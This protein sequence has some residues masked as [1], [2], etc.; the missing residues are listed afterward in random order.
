MNVDLEYD[1]AE[2]LKRQQ[3]K[4]SDVDSLRALVEKHQI[5]PKSITNKQVRGSIKVLSS[6]CDWNF[7]S[8]QLLLFLDACGGPEEGAR[9]A[10]IYYEIKKNSPEHF[11]NRDP[12]SPQIQQCLS[13]Q[14]YFYLPNKPNGDLIVFHRLSSSRASDYRFDEAIKTFFM[15]IDSCLQK[16]G[17]RDGAI[18]LFDMKNVGLM[19]LTRVNL[20]S[21]KKF[22]SYLQEGVPG[23][24]RAIHVLNTVYFMEKILAMIKPFLRADILK[25]VSWQFI[26]SVTFTVTNFFRLINQALLAF[27]QHE[28]RKVLRGAHTEVLLALRLWWWL[29]VRSGVT[30]KAQQRVHAIKRVLRRRRTTSGTATRSLRKV[31]HSVRFNQRKRKRLAQHDI[32]RLKLRIVMDF[33]ILLLLLYR[34]ILWKFKYIWGP[35]E[36]VWDEFLPGFEVFRSINW[37]E[38]SPQ[39]APLWLIHSLKSFTIKTDHCCR[40]N[41]YLPRVWV[42]Y[43]C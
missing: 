13:H 35:I 16:N 24:L 41:D 5:I 39:T 14:N 7:I 36:T 38:I 26:K 18:F 3:H 32:E 15:T 4:Q 40:S 25:A 21:I 8:L 1:Y 23:K 10:K 43:K 12:E 27:L 19:H 22:F 29:G 9:V 2:A 17:P 30:W 28:L 11:K 6:C 20:T 31:K 42:I 33:T 37:W 34:L